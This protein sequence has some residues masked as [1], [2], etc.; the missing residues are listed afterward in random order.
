MQH[1]L[2]ASGNC[3]FLLSREGTPKPQSPGMPL[4]SSIYADC[5]V[6]LGL[7]RYA[8]ASSDRAALDFALKLYQSVTRRIESGRFNS[9]PYPVPSGYKPHGIPMIML[10]TSQE[11]AAAL[12]TAGRDDAAVVGQA[13]ESYLRQ[14]L[15][16]A[17]SDNTLHEYIT[18]G[19][20]HEADTLL[21]RHTNPGHTIEDMWFVMHQARH[22][23]DTTV[24]GQMI[25]RAGQIIKRAFAI[26]WDAEYGGL[27]HFADQE[28]GQPRGNMAGMDNIRVVQQVVSGWSDKLWWVHS[29]ALYATLLAWRLT[30]DSDILALYHQTRDYTFRTFPNPDAAIGEWIQIRDRQGRPEQKVVALPV[31]DPFHIIRNVA[32]IIDLLDGL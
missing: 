31:K 20:D 7:S 8:A 1:C 13:A 23:S 11:L 16:F 12:A 22:S 29:E 15:V 24:A 9:E 10:N 32:L 2:L 19:D 18:T 27:L 26:G 6:I 3:A 21:G 17:T 14:A 25:A 30:G 4:D 5:F 28:G